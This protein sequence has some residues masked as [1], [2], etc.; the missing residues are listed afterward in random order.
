MYS[1]TWILVDVEFQ[2]NINLCYPL[3]I[4]IISFHKYHLWLEQLHYLK[5]DAIGFLTTREHTI[6]KHMFQIADECL[7]FHLSTFDTILTSL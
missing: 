5:N 2:P 4:A 1:Q 7:P 3:Y 6:L